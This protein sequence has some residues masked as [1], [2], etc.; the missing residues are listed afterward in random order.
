MPSMPQIISQLVG[1][2][3]VATHSNNKLSQSYVKSVLKAHMEDSEYCWRKCLYLQTEVKDSFTKE[4]V[5][6]IGLK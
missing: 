5:F 3:Y 6:E 1:K 4:T 2:E